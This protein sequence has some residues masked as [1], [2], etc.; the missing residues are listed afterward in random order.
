ML[1]LQN[2]KL[3]SK[4]KIVLATEEID[5]P[6]GVFTYI[7]GIN[8]SGKSLLLKTL[9]GQY[10]EY[11]GQIL[12]KNQRHSE[13][14]KQNNILLINNELPVIENITFLKNIEI[15]IG[16]INQNQKNRLLEMASIVNIVNIFND[17]MVLCSR[18]ERMMMYI[19][20]A[21]LVSPSVL[22]IDDFDTFFDKE[23]LHEIIQ[24]FKYMQ[25]SRMILIATGKTTIYDVPTYKLINGDMVR[26]L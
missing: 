18:S 21:A 1:R 8:S 17:E 6:V 24:L 10:K 5:F 7:Q 11:K 3:F 19:F 23:K 14:I 13:A 26:M 16:K 25:K 15:P 22:L 2:F 4:D 12:F 20:R 9:C